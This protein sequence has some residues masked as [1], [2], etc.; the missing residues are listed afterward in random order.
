MKSTKYWVKAAA[1]AALYAVLTMAVAPL[2][3]GPVQF[4]VSEA[5]TVLPVF[6]TAAIPGLTAGCLLAN[7]FGGYGAL[8]VVFGSLATLLATLCSYLLRGKKWLAPLPPVLFN[9]VIVGATIWVAAPNEGALW[10]NMV[11]V[12]LG[13]LGACYVLGM[14]LLFLLKK[15]PRMLGPETL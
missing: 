10:F 14:P 9:A 3:Y 15:Y 6:T 5:L 1:I 7:L 12:G 11:T 2:A 4:R 8:D 13:E